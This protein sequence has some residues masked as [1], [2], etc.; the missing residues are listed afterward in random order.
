MCDV[1][2]P[3]ALTGWQDVLSC[4]FCLDV[5][6]ECIRLTHSDDAK[7]CGACACVPCLK[8]WL[9]SCNVKRDTVLACPRCRH[10]LL[11]AQ[12]HKQVRAP[13]PGDPLIA[14]LLADVPA[15]CRYCSASGTVA[16]MAKHHP[17]CLHR[18]LAR[19]QD[20]DDLIHQA[21]CGGPRAPEGAL[22]RAWVAAMEA[23]HALDPTEAER[24][25]VRWLAAS[26]GRGIDYAVHHPFRALFGGLPLVTLAACETAWD[27]DA[28]KWTTVAGTALYDWATDATPADQ[29]THTQTRLL[30]RLARTLES[31]DPVVL[32]EFTR[33]L[34][35]PVVQRLPPAAVRAFIERIPSLGGPPTT[36]HT[37]LLVKCLEWCGG[38]FTPDETLALVS[39]VLAMDAWWSNATVA[40]CVH[41][42]SIERSALSVLV[43]SLTAL[44][45]GRGPPQD[46][47]H[48]VDA[49]M[50]SLISG[51]YRFEGNPTALFAAVS[52][53]S[54]ATCDVLQ[55]EHRGPL[56]TAFANDLVARHRPEADDPPPPL[57]M[58]SPRIALFLCP[59]VEPQHTREPLLRLLMNPYA[60]VGTDRRDI[61]WTVSWLGHFTLA[62]RMG[63]HTSELAW[64][65]I[66][67]G[68]AESILMGAL[69]QADLWHTA[70][71][72]RQWN[73]ARIVVH[74]VV[75]FAV[76][77]SRISCVLAAHTV[78]HHIG[79][80]RRPEEVCPRNWTAQ[81]P[82]FLGSCLSTFLCMLTDET[83]LQ[84]DTLLLFL[85]SHT[86]AVLNRLL[87][88]SPLHWTEDTAAAV[89]RHTPARWVERV[90]WSQWFRASVSHYAQRGAI[91]TMGSVSNHRHS[92]RRCCTWVTLLRVTSVAPSDQ[93]APRH[94]DAMS[95][96]VSVGAGSAEVDAVLAEWL[97]APTPPIR[98]LLRNW[99]TAA[100][101]EHAESYLLSHIALFC[102]QAITPRLPIDI[103]RRLSAA[104]GN[105]LHAWTRSRMDPSS[106]VDA[107]NTLWLVVY[108]GDD[109][110]LVAMAQLWWTDLRKHLI[111]VSVASGNHF[112][113]VP[114]L[115]RLEFRCAAF[116]PPVIALDC[117]CMG[118]HMASRGL[119]VNSRPLMNTLRVLP[120]RRIVLG[121]LCVIGCFLYVRPSRVRVIVTRT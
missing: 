62:D 75:A 20:A 15:H 76:R 10:P 111:A 14:R 88:V 43:P 24:Y 99:A 66:P 2:M 51:T 85:R 70:E 46:V 100:V 34:S 41:R 65:E 89:V 87:A 55:P 81:V 38:G 64:H 83:F 56:W 30:A 61:R 119:W 73:W 106:I 78:T 102:M 116:H 22:G 121:K 98:V 49:T 86:E 13:N 39:P 23:V 21:M 74:L 18:Q 68:V 45:R 4:P 11:V 27:N 58:L 108:F 17:M 92:S 105:H 35:P 59:A 60:F 120:D 48:S 96:F 115:Q 19:L 82:L 53:I 16:S 93:R 80:A 103:P 69:E 26:E 109:D 72:D 52:S 6:T 3:D 113:P 114:M 110:A 29:R 117:L 28:P 107:C 54:T 67:D 5:A 37:D 84:L 12:L 32:T 9:A 50:A 33:A 101:A 31:D 104:V 71:D 94:A 57:L 42:G 112:L 25:L 47:A 44:W 1:T 79:H 90:A 36:A 7:N 91:R 95:R 118:L 40:H 63:V 97:V 77:A 8:D